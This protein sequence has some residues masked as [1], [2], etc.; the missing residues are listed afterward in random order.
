M[1]MILA[2]PYFLPGSDDQD[3]TFATTSLCFEAMDESVSLHVPVLTPADIE[4]VSQ[5]LLEAQARHLAERPIME[6]VDRIDQVVQLWLDP[7]YPYRQQAEA[8]L[9][10]ITRYTVPMVRHGLDTLL[11][12]FRK[13]SLWRLLESE[14][15]NPLVLDAFQPRPHAGG[16]TRAYGPRLITHVFSG[17]VPALP[18]WSLICALLTKSASLGKS[19]SEEPLFAA[20]FARSLWDVCPDLG[21]CLAVGWWKGGDI[22]LERAAFA[23]SEAVIAYG[24]ETAI[25]DIQPRVPP[26]TQFLAYGHKL[27]FGVISRDVLR[28]DNAAPLAQQAAY[29]VSVFDQQ[30]C[31]SPHVLYVE[32]GGEISPKDFAPLL[33]NAMAAVHAELPRG[34]L[35]LED[36]TAIRHLR[37][38]YEFRA[39]ADDSVQ[40]FC[41]EPGTAWTVIY[42]EDEPFTPSC[43]NRTIRVHP[44]DD[45]SDIVAR[46][47]PVRSYLQTAGVAVA[48]S[49]LNRLAEALGRIGVTRLSSLNQMPW[50]TM[51][52]HH[53]GRCNLLDLIRW[54]DI[55]GDLH[56]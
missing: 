22:A 6:I 56:A 10:I 8:V 17:N 29:G 5:R 34:P 4:A 11:N 20:L 38:T 28:T 42:E 30:G 49:R 52:W 54:T 53:D 41:S 31:V 46:L 3:A 15:G 45:L 27:S 33:A 25:R 12:S 2:P 26:D 13:E 1:A 50:P 51:T 55:E 43:L 37:G 35:P 14:F 7:Q 39:L 36:S 44:V 23:N 24:S 32:Q 48:P 19:A 40:L 16:L 18:A 21:S 9:P 47:T